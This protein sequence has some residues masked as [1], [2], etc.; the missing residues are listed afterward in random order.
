MFSSTKIV[1]NQGAV[2]KK[3]SQMESSQ[4]CSRTRGAR[5]A[6]AW[7]KNVRQRGNWSSCWNSGQNSRRS[8]KKT[9]L[10]SSEIRP[11][12]MSRSNNNEPH[13][14]RRCYLHIQIDEVVMVLSQQTKLTDIG[15]WWVV[16]AETSPFWVLNTI[17]PK[18]RQLKSLAEVRSLNSHN[19][20]TFAMR[21]EQYLLIAISSRCCK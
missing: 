16:C 21:K 9:R 11:S 18:T 7:N 6:V 3:K 13:S 2:S 1:I 10:T 4:E 20:R 12:L 19:R 8:G 15:K 17:R 14:K 5:R